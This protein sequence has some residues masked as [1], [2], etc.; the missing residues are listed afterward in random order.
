MLFPQ[1]NENS[2]SAL[3]LSNLNTVKRP[4]T[5]TREKKVNRPC[6]FAINHLCAF[7]PKCIELLLITESRGMLELRQSAKKPRAITTTLEVTVTTSS[8][9]GER[10]FQNDGLKIG[11]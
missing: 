5:F 8:D 3:C 2:K 1:E 11:I 6:A 10:G 4:F 9:W 7:L